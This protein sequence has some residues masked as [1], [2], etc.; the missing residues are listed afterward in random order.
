MSFGNKVKK[1]DGA[2][3]YILLSV[4]YIFYFFTIACCHVKKHVNN[5]N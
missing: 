5:W 2:N 1:T 4:Q 3:K